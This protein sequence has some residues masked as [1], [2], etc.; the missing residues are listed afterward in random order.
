MDHESSQNRVFESP[1]SAEINFENRKLA[2]MANFS[3][4]PGS[5]YGSSLI[6]PIKECEWYANINFHEILLKTHCVLKF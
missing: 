3:V 4:V 6:R 2:K 1:S 5:E